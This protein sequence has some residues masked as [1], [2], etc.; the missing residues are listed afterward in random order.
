VRSNSL[1]MIRHH[2]H[3]AADGTS[4]DMRAGLNTVGRVSRPER[5]DVVIIG[6]GLLGLATACALRGRR[7]VVVLERETVGHG[8]AGSHGPSRIFRLGYADRVYVEM[9]HRALDGWR[10]LAAETGRQLLERTGQLSFGRGA[11]EVLTALRAAGAPV[12]E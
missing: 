10:D 1:D 12:E 11:V 3:H 6:G 9:A 5:A 4:R 7:E 8:R 2:G